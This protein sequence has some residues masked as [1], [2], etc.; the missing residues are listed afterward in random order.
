MTT[1]KLA[2]IGLC[3]AVLG[4]VAVSAQDQPG[5]AGKPE[6]PAKG[7][8]PRGAFPDLVAGLK[9]T[10]GCLGVEAARTQS[11][12][13]VLFAWFEDKKAL[14][15]WYR[16]EMHQ[17]TMAMMGATTRKDALKDVPEE[18]PVLAIASITF[19]DK[20]KLEG[21]PLPISQISIELYR[22]LGGG[23]NVGGRFA[24]EAMKLPGTVYTPPEK[25]EK[26][27]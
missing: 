12:K 18:G 23:L 9:A 10:P 3:A 17:E 6:A 21:I 26:D 25:T 2:M 20:P 7:A 15:A 13:S 27:R 14:M 4:G 22:P 11:G 19:T 24:P 16:S 1:A 8:V 5:P